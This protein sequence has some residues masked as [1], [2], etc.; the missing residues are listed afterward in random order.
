M[1]TPIDVAT[2][3]TVSF[4]IEHVGS[5]ATILEVGC[6]EGGVALELMDRGYQIT[7][8]DTDEDTVAKAR[9]RGALVQLVEWPDYD[10]DPVDAIVFTRSLHHIHRL[11][12]A[13]V[14]AKEL[15]K[16]GGTILAEDFAFDVADAKTIEWFLSVINTPKACDLLTL[17]PGE[18]IT[19]LLAADDPE[20]AWQQDHDHELHTIGAMKDAIGEHFTIQ[21]TVS[22][23]Y[24][25]R[26]L[27]PVLPE[28]SEAVSVVQKTF[29]DETKAGDAGNITFIG[30]RIVASRVTVL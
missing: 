8:L 2:D 14:K 30:R 28:T 10:C 16:P 23:P 15:L 26:Y 5:P 24:L 7:G 29:D 18:F 12:A 9:K 19:N 13:I 6:G 11:D 4:I 22:V 20:F 21:D 17:I 25:Y 27:I 3:A 1:T